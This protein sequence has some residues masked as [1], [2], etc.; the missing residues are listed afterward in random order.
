MKTCTDKR[1]A[2]TRAAFAPARLFLKN[3]P[4]KTANTG[5]QRQI[6]ARHP[7]SSRE[8]ITIK[9]VQYLAQSAAQSLSNPHGKVQFL[10]ISGGTVTVKPSRQRQSPANSVSTMNVNVKTAPQPPKKDTTKLPRL[11]AAVSSCSFLFS[12]LSI[13]V[14]L[15]LLKNT[16]DLAEIVVRDKLIRF[17]FLYRSFLS[18]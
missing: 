10:A 11:C 8:K 15:I 17:F 9:T 18:L 14:V 4:Y 6:R 1:K 16:D 2:Q 13:I 3:A 5:A 12:S 7:A